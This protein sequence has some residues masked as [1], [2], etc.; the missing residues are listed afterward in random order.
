M[1][2]AVL[3][4]RRGLRG[5]K[6]RERQT[7][8]VPEATAVALAPAQTQQSPVWLVTNSFQRVRAVTHTGP[9]GG[10]LLWQHK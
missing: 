7:Q 5:R 8:K 9:S 10:L 2:R 1:L 6:A 3:V 4:E